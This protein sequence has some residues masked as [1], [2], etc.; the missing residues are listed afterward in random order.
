M[1][2]WVR[3]ARVWPNSCV[4]GRLKPGWAVA[5]QRRTGQGR[6]RD[7]GRGRGCGRDRAVSEVTVEVGT[8]ARRE[9]WWQ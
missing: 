7:W 3:A 9:S 1:Y 6:D 8:V 2:S 5:G 4:Q